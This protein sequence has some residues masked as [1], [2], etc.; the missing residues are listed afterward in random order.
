MEEGDVSLSETHEGKPHDDW[1]GV[2]AL[3]WGTSKRRGFALAKVSFTTKGNLFAP[4][5]S[6]LGWNETFVFDN[7]PPEA[8]KAQRIYQTRRPMESTY[9]NGIVYSPLLQPE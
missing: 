8:A 7:A 4:R 3:D 9:E 5:H 6:L 2:K 1:G